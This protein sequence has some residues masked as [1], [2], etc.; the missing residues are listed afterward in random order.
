MRGLRVNGSPHETGCTHRA[1]TEIANTLKAQGVDAEIHEV[2][3]HLTNSLLGLVE[4]DMLGNILEFSVTVFHG[5]PD[6][7]N[8][9]KN[10]K[11]E[12]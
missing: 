2:V 11:T 4:V 9:L 8:R 1:L 3:G 6:D 7:K 5:T 10:V 12:Q